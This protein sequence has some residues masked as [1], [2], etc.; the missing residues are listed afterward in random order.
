MVLRHDGLERSAVCIGG[1]LKTH[2][3]IDANTVQEL[4]TRAA[5]RLLSRLRR[6]G[7]L[8][9]PTHPNSYVELANACGQLLPVASVDGDAWTPVKAKLARASNLFLSREAAR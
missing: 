5:H 9:P 3:G 8:H 1:Y 4:G 7:D 2:G 6:K